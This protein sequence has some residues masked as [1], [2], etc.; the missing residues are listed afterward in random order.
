[1][2]LPLRTMSLLGLVSSRP[3]ACDVGRF[4]S[5]C[6]AII[7]LLPPDATE[8]ALAVAR[9]S[10]HARGGPGRDGRPPAVRADE[11]ADR[12]KAEQAARQI[13]IRVEARRLAEV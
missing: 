9:S 5:G 13:Q 11:R 8:R 12:Q 6:G 10:S 7:T 3:D 1:V 2:L 4:C